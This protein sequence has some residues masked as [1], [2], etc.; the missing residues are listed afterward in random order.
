MIRTCGLNKRFRLDSNL[1]CPEALSESQ[2]QWMRP[3]LMQISSI[4]PSFQRSAHLKKSGSTVP[5]RVIGI[6]LYLSLPALAL[7]PREKRRSEKTRGTLRIALK[8]HNPGGY[9]QSSQRLSHRKTPDVTHHS[10]PTLFLS[11]PFHRSREVRQIREWKEGKSGRGSC[12]S[13]ANRGRLRAGPSRAEQPANH[14]RS[15]ELG[16]R[17]GVVYVKIT[18]NFSSA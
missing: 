12:V 7:P 14:F 4:H 6:E 9:T 5:T 10:F 16:E 11:H 18:P 1:S 8:C 2:P 15:K 13:D 3:D 17:A